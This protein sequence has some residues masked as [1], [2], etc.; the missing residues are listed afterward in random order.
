MMK[1]IGGHP[2]WVGRKGEKFGVFEYVYPLECSYYGS[3]LHRVQ[4]SLCGAM[5]VKSR[6]E[7]QRAKRDDRK[8][9]ANCLAVER[10]AR[11]PE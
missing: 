4:C 11:V 10:Q 1:S 6:E 8:R 7:L 3:S 2:S 9:C 5:V